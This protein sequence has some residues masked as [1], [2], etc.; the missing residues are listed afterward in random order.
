MRLSVCLSLPTPHGHPIMAVKTRCQDANPADPLPYPG[1][2]GSQQL[3]LL[4]GHLNRVGLQEWPVGKMASLEPKYRQ[5]E[6][7]LNDQM[8]F[9]AES[10]NVTVPSVVTPG[11][12][13]DVNVRVLRLKPGGHH[14][15]QEGDRRLQTEGEEAQ[16]AEGS[17]DLHGE[18]SHT[19][20]RGH[21]D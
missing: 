20:D 9:V 18:G 4:E 3:L 6:L 12:L 17:P 14:P 21:Q 11:E 15:N 10:V 19:G 16:A 7:E 2:G 5:I 8:E 13:L 1:R